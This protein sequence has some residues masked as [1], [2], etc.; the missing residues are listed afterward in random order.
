MY[1][2][3]LAVLEPHA[4]G[5]TYLINGPDLLPLPSDRELEKDALALLKISSYLYQKRRHTMP[6]NLAVH[7]KRF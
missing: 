2:N 5:K 6:E 3:K 4:K 7:K 1:D